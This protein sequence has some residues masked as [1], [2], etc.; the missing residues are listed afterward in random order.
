MESPNLLAGD[1]LAVDIA[2]RPG[3]CPRERGT[4][5]A[6]SS[7]GERR[8]WY[9]I[10]ETTSP[11]TACR[12]RS[13]RPD[14]P[15]LG[16]RK[17][18]IARSRRPSASLTAW[19]GLTRTQ[20]QRIACSNIAC[21]ITIDCP[22]RMATNP[23]RLEVG[24]EIRNDLGVHLAHP[25]RA[26]ARLD[27]RHTNT[28]RRTP[29][30]EHLRNEPHPLAPRVRGIA[31][32]ICSRGRYNLR[33]AAAR[34]V[35]RATA[36]GRRMKIKW[37]AGLFGRSLREFWVGAGDDE[38]KRRVW[39]R[40]PAALLAALTALRCASRCRARAR[41]VRLG[42]VPV[43]HAAGVGD[44]GL[45]RELALGLAD[46]VVGVPDA[47]GLGR[48]ALVAG[49]EL[50][51]AQLLA[52]QRRLL[53]GVV[54]FAREQA[55]EQAGELACGRDD[56]DGVA[57]AG[58]DALVEGVQRAGLADRRPARLDERVAGAG[59]SPAWRCGR[60]SRGRA[61]TGARADPG[62]GSRPACAGSRSGRC[63]RSRPGSWRR[64]SRSR[65]ARSSAAGSAA[66]RAR[67]GRSAARPRRSPARGTR[68]GACSA[69]TV[70]RSSSA[71]SSP[72]SQRRPLTPNRSETGG[73]P[74]SWRISTA[75][76][77]FF[78][79]ERALTSWPRRDRRRRITQVARSG[80]QTASSDPAAS[81]LASVRASSRSVFARAWRMPVSRR[82]DDQHPRD[83]RLDDPRDLPR[84]ARHLQR[85]PIVRAQAPREQLELLRRRRDPPAQSEAR[86]PRRARPR[87]N[88]DA[89]P[90][91][92]ISPPPP[93]ARSTRR[94][95]RWA[96]DTDGSALEAQPD[97]SQGRPPKSP[98]SNAHRPR[99]GLPNMRSPRR[100][101]FRSPDPNHGRARTTALEHHFHAPKSGHLRCPAPGPKSREGTETGHDL[102]IAWTATASCRPRRPRTRRWLRLPPRW[103]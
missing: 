55:P 77:S 12:R 26:E 81:S 8:P 37:C 88:P 13:A 72:A 28:K 84:V 2:A 97:K 101:L 41:L 24:P 78:A 96:N 33:D 43:A 47:G 57:A 48:V 51:A 86:H 102:R 83:V 63:R 71:S 30:D 56:R 22:H 29:R 21:S 38:L 25:H 40:R 3:G 87:R 1:D 99:T 76:I 34:V 73:R 70:S 39:D 17:A 100:P 75:W 11:R 94:E 18:T 65:R 50:E 19:T 64:R 16:G 74:T 45:A 23:G 79:R 89:R 4:S 95:T 66:S 7:S 93:S 61:R 67:P 60:A 15:L 69:S 10:S 44:L 32:L 58:A 42:G 27:V 91:R 9:A 53:V 85:D 5:D 80:I 14:L 62:R 59:P 49:G 68:S 6:S 92:P 31:V 90:T 98:G 52:G 36:S 20:P 82:A 54:L 103:R 46:G 35:E